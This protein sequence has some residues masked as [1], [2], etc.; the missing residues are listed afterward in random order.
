MG[1]RNHDRI[2]IS[3]FRP[4]TETVKDMF[5][6]KWIVITKC[7]DCELKLY[8]NIVALMHYMGP[9]VSLWNK[10][11]RCLKV[12]CEGWTTFWAQRPY[13]NIYEELSAPWPEGGPPRPRRADRP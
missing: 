3:E 8:V 6:R 9:D 7:R 1:A 11:R 12:G 4:S 5:D 2:F 10:R 13:R